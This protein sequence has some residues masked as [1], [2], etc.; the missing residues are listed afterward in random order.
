M[1][2]TDEE[3]FARSDAVFVGE[4]VAYAPPPPPAT[5]SGDPATWT[6]AVSEVYKGDV[7]AS[8]EIV[9]AVSSAT[10]GISVPRQGQV[11]VFA[12]RQGFQL[13]LAQGQYAASLC[14]GT[15]SL[16]GGPL[17]LT[18]VLSPT[19]T[20]PPPTV[21]PP[22]VTPPADSVAPVDSAPGDPASVSTD[23]AAPAGR[24]ASAASAAAVRDHAAQRGQIALAAAPAS[25]D[26][27]GP[28]V[29]PIALATGGLVGL[30]AV[31]GLALRSRRRPG[32]SR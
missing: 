22:P 20:A 30:V 10:C 11:L 26:A 4:V 23:G 28:P 17:T 25:D 16:Q 14:G 6:F 12:T 18:P 15:R 5:S 13:P 24:V 31:L 21:L 8:Q 3:N 29:A 1:G 19:T 7:G 9:S 32:G 27:D 2:S